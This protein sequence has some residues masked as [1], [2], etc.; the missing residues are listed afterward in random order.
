MRGNKPLPILRK[1]VITIK[2]LIPD[3]PN[4][5]WREIEG[6]GGKYLVSNFGRIKSLKY[7][8]ARILAAFVNNKGYP[9]V[10]L[11]KDG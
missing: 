10:S 3:L 6:Y 1:D 2:T 5:V 4:E 11:S 7:P 8:K 9:R